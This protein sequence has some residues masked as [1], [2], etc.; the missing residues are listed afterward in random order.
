MFAYKTKSWHKNTPDS[1]F[2]PR[3]LYVYV[4]HGPGP[5]KTCFTVGNYVKL[6][7][8]CLAKPWNSKT[9]PSELDWL[10]VYDMKH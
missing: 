6:N 5:E 4:P 10:Q 8:V 2:N 3:S 7:P 1:A 9:E